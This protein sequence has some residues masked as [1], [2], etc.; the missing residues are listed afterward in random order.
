MA[1]NFRTIVSREQDTLLLELQG[2]FDG[3]SALDLIN[4]L[5]ENSGS[6]RVLIQTNGLSEVHPFGKA[7]FQ[8]H[9]PAAVRLNSS[10]VF[11][12]KHAEEIATPP[13]GDACRPVSGQGFLQRAAV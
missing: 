8:K 12:G 13:Q 11:I 6:A 10:I 2:D 9:L 4:A 7:V 3:T 1:A 5:L